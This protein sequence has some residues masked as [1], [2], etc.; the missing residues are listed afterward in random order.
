MGPGGLSD[1]LTTLA[2]GL[3]AFAILQNITVCYG[4]A[5]RELAVRLDAKACWAFVVASAVFD[6]AYLGGAAWCS[7]WSVR[8][9]DLSGDAAEVAK[10]VSYGR[11][12][13]ILLFGALPI[14][15]LI[16][17][18]NRRFWGA[19]A[20]I[21]APAAAARKEQVPQAR[22]DQASAQTASSLSS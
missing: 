15:M 14:L 6:L 13:A 9:A 18:N 3:T 2:D 11:G 19:S 21:A 1:E 17:Y 4:L 12:G 5:K 7:C 8:L 16:G 10:I 20:I 22:R